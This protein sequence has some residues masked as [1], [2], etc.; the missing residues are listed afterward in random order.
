MY[1]QEWSLGYVFRLKEVLSPNFMK[2]RV[3]RASPLVNIKS[4]TNFIKIDLK[5]GANNKSSLMGNTKS[6]IKM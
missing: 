4:Y 5:F 6:Y 2:K 3:S 1:V